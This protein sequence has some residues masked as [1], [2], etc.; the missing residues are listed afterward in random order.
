[1]GSNVVNN[2]SFPKEESQLGGE[3]AQVWNVLQLSQ[4]MDVSGI[5]G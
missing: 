1:M 2:G 5:L 3:M 4:G